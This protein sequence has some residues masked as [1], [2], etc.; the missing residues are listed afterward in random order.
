MPTF[1]HES[2]AQLATC[3]QRLQDILTD[4]IALIDFS[5]IEGHRGQV[6]QDR[7]F[8]KGL[9]KLKYP[10]GR[11]NAVPS[12]AADI[13]PFPLDWSEGE[14]PH[15][16][17]AF[18]QGVVYACA[19]RRGIKVRFGMDW[20]RNFDPRDESFLDLPHVELDEP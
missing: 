17:F 1:G 13:A 9:T 11:H 12:R 5:V 4:A 18:L 14:R 15:L 16:R 3:D 2:L 19:H 7:D 6:L 20:N 8:A 10:N